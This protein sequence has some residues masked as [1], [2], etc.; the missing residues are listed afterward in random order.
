[1]ADK[2][3][4]VL[5]KVK[6]YGDSLNDGKV[7]ISFALP[8]KNSSMAIEA[9]KEFVLKIGFKQVQVVFTKNMGEDFTFFILYAVSPISIDLSK[10]TI[11]QAEIEALSFDEINDFIHKK[12][13]RKI[14][15]AG[16]CTGSD[17]HTV[18]ID[19]ILNMKGYKGEPGLERYSQMKVYNL[20]AQLE[21]EILVYQAKKLKADAILV[22]QVV[23]QKD[24]HLTNLTHL[25]DFLDLEGL[26][27]KFILILGG[28]RI[29]SALAKELG[30]DAG[31]GANTYPNEVAAFIIKELYRRLKERCE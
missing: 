4:A 12:I 14:V 25:I 29:S 11:P 5:T 3:K 2:L 10:I 1:M 9:A 18:G 21:N 30:F 24:A 22:S 13:K 17:A 28:P 23:T 7:Q 8:I 20:G 19:A 31:F 16:A 15:V 6:P 26:R 27:D